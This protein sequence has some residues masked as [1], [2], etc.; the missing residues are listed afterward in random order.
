MCI[1]DRL[2]VGDYDPI[3]IDMDLKD[4]TPYELG[5]FYSYLY[6]R[7]ATAAA[8]HLYLDDICIKKVV[9]NNNPEVKNAVQKQ[10][11]KVGTELTV[12]PVSYTH[13]DVYKRQR[14]HNRKR[15]EAGRSDLLFTE[16]TGFGGQH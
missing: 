2:T 10:T 9:G 14:I 12:N 15:T 8:T 13:L 6:Y 5:G 4:S 7:A 11:V 3:S 1:R 16:L